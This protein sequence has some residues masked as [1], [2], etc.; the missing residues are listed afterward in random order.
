MLCSDWLRL[1]PATFTTQM[2][3]RKWILFWILG[4]MTWTITRHQFFVGMVG[5]HNLI[6][7]NPVFIRET[8]LE[9][10]AIDRD[11]GSNGL[12]KYSI[13]SGDNRRVF[14]MNERNGK[15]SL[16]KLLS[17]EAYTL[18]IRAADSGFIKKEGFLRLIISVKFITPAPSPSG[19][20]G[21]IP[22]TTK[23][24]NGVVGMVGIVVGPLGGILLTV[25]MA[26]FWLKSRRSVS[27]PPP[28]FSVPPPPLEFRQTVLP[29]FT[30]RCCVCTQSSTCKFLFKFR[31]I[32]REVV[33]LHY[34]NFCTRR[35]LITGS[36][37][38]RS[39]FRLWIRD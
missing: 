35:N 16:R 6:L 37:R 19:L 24:D 13:V 28:E 38:I 22:P 11:S 7:S 36:P 1:K 12:V 5:F 39:E 25:L 10:Q 26:V 8:I 34:L 23:A 33:S 14:H 18:T 32:Y 9:V 15:I 17:E 20:P 30:G 21:N 31:L 4:W 29:L 3:V 27:P 2:E